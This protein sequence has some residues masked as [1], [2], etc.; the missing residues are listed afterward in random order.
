MEKTTD[1]VYENVAKEAGGDKAFTEFTES[2][3]AQTKLVAE[4]AFKARESGLGDAPLALQWSLWLTAYSAML[5]SITQKVPVRFGNLIMITAWQKV[6]KIEGAWP[7]PSDGDLASA[8]RW[9]KSYTPALID[10]VAGAWGNI[11]RR[12]DALPPKESPP[13]P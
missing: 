4:F 13:A 3:I 9:I 1:D 8:V 7:P 12:L 11:R 2:F 10:S 5:Y 6:R